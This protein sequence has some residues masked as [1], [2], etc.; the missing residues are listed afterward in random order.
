MLTVAKIS[1]NFA[2]CIEMAVNQGYSGKPLG[3]KLGIKSGFNARLV[4]SPDYYHS[5]FDD[6]PDDVNFNNDSKIFQDF[7]MVR[8]EICYPR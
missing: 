4:D 1:D 6:L 3:K 2:F 7:I 8:T 5:L